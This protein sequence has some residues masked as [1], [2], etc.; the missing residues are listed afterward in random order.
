MGKPNQLHFHTK[1]WYPL[2]EVEPRDLS[3]KTVVLIGANVGLG[4]EAAKHF[5]R[6]Q[7]TKLIIACRSIQKCEDTVEEIRTATGFSKITGYTVDLSVFSSVVEF[8]ENLEREQERLDILVYSAAV[9]TQ[10][11]NRTGDGYEQ[12]MQVNDLSCMLLSILLLPCMMET[13]KTSAMTAPRP[14]L[15]VVSSGAHFLVTPSQDVLSSENVLE[16]YSDLDYCSQPGVMTIR[17]HLTKLLNVFFVRELAE[18]LSGSPIIACTV[19][20]GYCKTMLSRNVRVSGLAALRWWLYATLFARTAEMGS[21]TIV[22]AAVSESHR[23]KAL[24][25]HFLSDMEV[26]EESDFAVSKEGFAMQKKLWDEMIQVFSQ[27]SPRFKEIVD[28]YFSSPQE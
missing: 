25:G 21:R 16:K 20:P 24:H 2:P 18:R 26:R 6:M 23:E 5:A 10:I 14:R 27:V 7:P 9:A 17:Y 3:G 15:V 22:W 28:R 8:A 19:N 1:Q 12:S 4:L 11:Y 13:A